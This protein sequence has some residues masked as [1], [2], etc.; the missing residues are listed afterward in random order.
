MKRT[1]LMLVL[2]TMGVVASGQTTNWGRIDSLVMDGHYT[3]ARPMA[4]RAWRQAQEGADGKESL[5]AAFYLT[6]IDYA[7]DKYPTDSA[8]ARYT[9]LTRGLQ[10]T[11]RAVAYAFLFQTYGQVYYRR[12]YGFER[13][14]P[15]DDPKLPY[16]LWHRQRMED[17]LM[18]CVDSIVACADLLRETS[19]DAYRRMFRCD[20]LTPPPIDSSLLSMLVQTLVGDNG[21]NRDFRQQV[22][23][24]VEGLYAEGSADIALWLA[25]QRPAFLP[26]DSL[27][28]ATLDSIDRRYQTLAVGRDM[29]ALLNYHRASALSALDREVDAEQLCIETE[30][31]YP[32]TYGA[33]CCRQLRRRICQQEYIIRFS[34]TESSRSSR[35]AVIEARNT[36]LLHLRL[37]RQDS[38][39]Y[40]RLS[41]SDDTLL[42]LGAV[43]EWDQ[44][45]PDPG[46]HL[47]HHYLVAL[48]AVVQGDYYLVAYTDSALCYES[49]QSADA[50]FIAY[51]LPYAAGKKTTLW[52][53]S[54]H[55]VDRLTGQ[56]LAGKKVTLNG[57][58]GITGHE[59]TRHCRTDKKGYFHF[60]VS[61]WRY[62]FIHYNELS[63]DIDGYEFSFND[64]ANYWERVE[65]ISRDYKQTDHQIQLVMTDRP[66]YR[67]GDTVQFLCVA[68]DRSEHGSRWEQRIRPAK[69][70]KLKA[71]F[72]HSNTH[73]EDTLSLTTDRYGR[74]WGRFVV[75]ADG[76]NGIYS[77]GVRSDDH[78][79]SEYGYVNVEAYKP[80][81]FTVTLSTS[82][83]GV[84]TVAVHRMGQPVTLYGMA[85]SYSGAP[86]TGA[87]VRWEVSRERLLGPFQWNTMADEYPYHD[88]LTVNDDGTF[89]FT[90]TP[91][92]DEKDT[93]RYTTYVYTA[94]VHVTDA[95]GEL[96]ES[97]L[98]VRVSGTD[99]YCLLASLHTDTGA[100]LT[101]LYNN[102]DHQP[103]KGQVHVT[104]QQLRQPDTLRILDPRLMAEYRDARWVGSEADFRRQFPHLAFT[105][106]EAD[107]RRWPV[108]ET[109]LDTLTSERS[110]ALG[111]LPSGIY[112]ILFEMP[113]GMRHDT[114]VNHVAPGGRVTG[115]DLVWLRTTPRSDYYWNP[116][117][118]RVGDTLRIEMGS[119]FGNQALYYR[120]AN[121]AKI[122]SQGMIM[123]D[124][125]KTTQL[126]IPITKTM[127][128]DRCV[129]SLAAVRDGRAFQRIFE[130][131]VLRPELLC[132]IQ[133]ET[134][135][136]R[137]QPGEQEQWRLRITGADSAG[138]EANLCMT[139]YDKSLEQYRW[140]RFGFNPW[141]SRVDHPR[142]YINVSETLSGHFR[143]ANI[144]INAFT[145][146]YQPQLGYS[147]WAL[148]DWHKQIAL[149]YRPGSIVGTITDAKTDEELPF[150]NVV[151][152]YNGKQFNG[153]STDFDGRFFF[154]SLPTG[155]YELEISTVG[156]HRAICKVTVNRNG[157]TVCNIQLSPEASNLECIE[158]VSDKVPM[159]EIG[160]PESGMRL[161]SDDIQRMPGNSV[162]SIVAAV[163]GVG[164]DDGTEARKRTGVNVPKE[165]IAEFQ[166]AFDF[167]ESSNPFSTL[168]SQFSIRKNL[169]T[170]AFFE[171]A[172]RSGKDGSV[173]V[174]FTMPDALTQWS[175][176]AFAWTDDYA[177]GA[178]ERIVQTQ[179]EL[180]VQP[181]LPRFLRQ[182][183]TVELRAKVSNLS[184]SALTAEVK[185]EMG[186]ESINTSLTSGTSLTS[187]TSETSTLHIAPHTSGI[188]SFRF[189]V[190]EGKNSGMMPYKVVARSA[191]HGDGE[192]G[193][194][195]VLSDKERVT[196]SRLLYI[197]GSPD[198]SEVRRSYTRPAPREGDS[199]DIAFSARP[200]DY[201]FEAL[202]H[203]ERH[204][205][206]GNIYLANSAFA[207]HIA[208]L[209]PTATEKE[210]DRASERVRSQLHDLLQAQHS[211]G[212]WSW[213]PKGGEASLFTTEVVLQ[214]LA[215]CPSLA[216]HNRYRRYYKKAI[217]Y[218]DRKL[219]EQFQR[220]TT[221]KF[222]T[223]NSQ[224]SI[225][226]TRSLW[227]D[228]KPLSECD[229]VTLQAYAYYLQRCRM[230]SGKWKTE[231][232]KMRFEGLLALTL[233]HM[234]DTAEAVRVATRIRERAHVADTLGMYWNERSWYRTPVEDAALMVDVMAEVLHDWDA[235]GRIQQW[236]LSYRQG[237]TWRTDM[238]TASAIAALLRTPEG[239]AAP[240]TS[241]TATLTKEENGSTLT[242][243]LRSTSPYPAWGAVFYSHEAPLDSIRTEG[244]GITL[245]RTFSI[246]AADGSLSLVKPG[247]Q[248]RVGERVRVHID[249]YCERDLDR[250]VMRDQRAAGFEPVSTKSGWRWNDGL[251]YYVDIRDEV[252]DCYIDRLNEGHYYVEYDL[253]VRHAGTFATGICTLQSVYAPEFRC[254]TAS[255]RLQIN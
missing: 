72:S 210:R 159:I 13:N 171:P 54:G 11:D 80:P 69:N 172:L 167:G 121:A 249:L 19:P 152:K 221:N 190:N 93:S 1:F 34:Q 119:P 23:R 165:A 8:I 90:F 14:N 70:L 243:E 5:L 67:L 218:L 130:L 197:A 250:L 2:A 247:Q 63:A 217:D 161:S 204:R 203:F 189:A 111:D 233:L 213:M 20:S 6:A 240:D 176:K 199:L 215:A 96:Q 193:L 48:P 194:L 97:Q 85:A 39:S 100:V 112:R 181:Q 99:G 41:W 79:Y 132:N 49:Y 92:P 76:R 168:N 202:P 212:G 116:I 91:T 22:F 43:A 192:S 174:A 235:V 125:S 239:L 180:M 164:Y 200:M 47:M 230:E 133:T 182:G 214:R 29:R 25:L 81:H 209:N 59:R 87:Q 56:P 169:S 153:T 143:P 32:G 253:W 140:L 122:I 155:S 246:V 55:L 242:I 219:V 191:H 82:E 38:L 186:E 103:L 89:Q 57:E 101:Y 88:S 234:G 173:T 62:H 244:T 31:L 251:H 208:S 7:Y 66:V 139:M 254:H 58:G 44:P 21:I 53:S 177:L 142:T 71:I 65:C 238:A 64:R 95:D 30:G 12:F 156:Y 207:D 145:V 216:D 149:R 236:I 241:R 245:R 105:P 227:L 94:H 228:I 225:L 115:T 16:L 138:I 179:K 75:P 220:D 188:A 114:V 52:P 126:S 10:G 33:R 232:G 4:E 147:L 136:D 120:V 248:L 73:H 45:L 106:E 98:S 237:T 185:F 148:D 68:Y 196:T 252:S 187:L 150:V 18:A 104:L 102:F 74:C 144:L 117:T 113:D 24:R 37:V 183:D 17:T 107:P 127:K 109:R 15:S 175:V 201:A 222:S 36:P 166:P 84:D 86:M 42:R 137:L 170:L 123:L 146:G 78:R 129:V 141:Y 162:E 134:F 110:L 229:S 195:P 124:N 135:R 83:E 151:L 178:L 61:S 9:S 131:N 28:A 224:F 223:L 46:D 35:L 157:M 50:L 128:G 60:P 108:V 158:I 3:T 211:D 206:P 27:Y 231:S 118:C 77:L 160:T 184:D 205:M 255:D 40:D 226:Y 154:Q 163:G 51:G 26:S 198:G